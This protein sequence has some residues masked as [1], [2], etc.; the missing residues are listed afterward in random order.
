MTVRPF[1]F[2]LSKEPQ[3]TEITTSTK[4]DKQHGKKDQ[5]KKPDLLYKLQIM[6]E[7]IFHLAAIRCSLSSS[8][9]W[10]LSSTQHLQN[11]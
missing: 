4:D 6:V 5:I 10:R 7:A 1:S 8:K 11:E 3:T 9:R 2:F